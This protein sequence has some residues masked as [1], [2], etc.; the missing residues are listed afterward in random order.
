MFVK[1]CKVL[2]NSLFIKIKN[3]CNL[4]IFFSFF[5]SPTENGAKYTGEIRNVSITDYRP[6][7]D[8]GIICSPVAH[9]FVCPSV[10]AFHMFN[11]P[12]L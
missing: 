2:R 4:I 8:S 11:S 3:V 5:Y 12:N 6:E 7:G 1:V 10:L 9:L